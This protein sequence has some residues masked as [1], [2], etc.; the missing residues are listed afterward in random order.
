MDVG[1]KKYK[2][3]TSPEKKLKACDTFKIE[4]MNALKMFV[5]KHSLIISS[6]VDRDSKDFFEAVVIA[7]AKKNKELR[8]E[9]KI[10]FLVDEFDA[11]F[12]KALGCNPVYEA[13]NEFIGD[14][15]MH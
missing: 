5:A 15:Y 7:A 2:K 12:R 10:V 11:P 13:I 3:A 9:E 1:V 6:E 8:G 14:I 4:F